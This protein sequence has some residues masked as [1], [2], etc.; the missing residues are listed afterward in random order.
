MNEETAVFGTGCFWCSEAIFQKVKGVE[1]VRPGYA[2]GE[3]ENPSYEQV[4]EGSTGHAEVVEVTFD[5]K[6]IKYEELLDIFWQIHDP[7]TWNRQGN[8]VGTQYRSII[9]YTSEDQKRTAEESKGKLEAL[10]T[11]GVESQKTPG[12]TGGWQ[13]KSIVTEIKELKKFYEAEKYHH[14]Y[15]EKNPDQGYC[16]VII[17]PKLEHFKKRFGEYMQS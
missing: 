4:C 13:G 8:D 10:L 3:V 11:S 16:R 5:P 6:V 15:F 9:L 7:T 2:G 17:A 14:N 12:V 1:S